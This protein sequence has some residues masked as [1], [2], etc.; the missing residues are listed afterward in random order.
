MTA[1]EFKCKKCGAKMEPVLIASGEE[2]N[3]V[4]EKYEHRCPECGN[5]WIVRE[6]IVK[7]RVAED[8]WDE[9]NMV[10]TW[11][12]WRMYN[13][14]LTE[15]EVRDLYFHLKEEYG[16]DRGRQGLQVLFPLQG[17]DGEEQVV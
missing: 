4:W 3:T 6:T 8:T 15:E 11:E 1:M 14:V 7:R 16:N 5:E 17:L 13:K 9:W 2:D 10:E 12:E